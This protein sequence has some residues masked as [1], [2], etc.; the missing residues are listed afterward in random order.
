MKSESYQY[1]YS[2]L[3]GTK[4]DPTHHKSIIPK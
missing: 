2:G 1:D 4:F 3:I